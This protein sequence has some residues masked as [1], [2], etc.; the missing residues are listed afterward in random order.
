MPLG[1]EQVLIQVGVSSEEQSLQ[2]VHSAQYFSHEALSV[3]YT[4]RMSA[5]VYPEVAVTCREGP[6]QPEDSCLD[7]HR[8]LPGPQRCCSSGKGLAGA[9]EPE[10]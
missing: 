2:T 8:H 5:C 10:L 1:S 3:R 7:H 9:E 4:D 6:E